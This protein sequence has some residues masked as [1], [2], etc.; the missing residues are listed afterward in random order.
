MFRPDKSEPITPLESHLKLVMHVRRYLKQLLGLPGISIN[1]CDSY[2]LQA[3]V[4]VGRGK[5]LV[6]RKVVTGF[7][8]FLGGNLI[9]WKS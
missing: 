8:V 6:R 4:D 5:C 7:G 2:K 1:K 9:S 3:F